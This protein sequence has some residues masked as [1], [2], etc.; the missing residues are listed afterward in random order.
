MG[1]NAEALENATYDEA[2]AWLLQREEDAVLTT[3]V[4]ID[5]PE[6][7]GTLNSP[8]FLAWYKD[9]EGVL[10]GVCYRYS[11]SGSGSTCNWLDC[12]ERYQGNTQLR[13]ICWNKNDRLHNGTFR[14]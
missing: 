10:C 11:G 8:E 2:S 14:E 1:R 9:Y 6:W 7:P 4:P 12:A 5:R 3:A 13:G